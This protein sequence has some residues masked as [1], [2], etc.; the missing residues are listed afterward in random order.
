MTTFQALRDVVLERMGE[1]SNQAAASATEGEIGDAT[2][3]T[4]MLDVYRDLHRRA[5]ERAPD[6]FTSYQTFSYTANAE[7]VS[8]ASVPSP[9]LRYASILGLYEM[10]D[11]EPVPLLALSQAEYERY[12][13]SGSL[14]SERMGDYAYYIDNY[15]L[16]LL[17]KPNAAVSIRARYV[18][19]LTLS[20]TTSTWGSNSPDEFPDKFHSFIA[21]ET[22][23]RFLAERDGVP[24]ALER[25]RAETMTT[26]LRWAADDRRPGT[27][28]VIEV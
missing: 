22:A 4:R 1:Y 21:L 2:I 24:V 25:E 9:S 11:D 19:E 6:R 12:L 7:Y 8:L 10:V 3:L 5:C 18:P 20:I 13:S 26:F 17:P 14:P 28:R 15:N 23:I 16:H 27:R